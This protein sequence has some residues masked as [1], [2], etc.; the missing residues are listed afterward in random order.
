[1]EGLVV[2]PCKCVVWSPSRLP[3]RF[4]LPSSF[5]ILTKGIKVLGVLLGSISFTS[6]FI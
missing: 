2:Q 6:S 4:S 3:L 5:Y 1:L